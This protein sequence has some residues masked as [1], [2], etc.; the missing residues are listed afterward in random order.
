[1]SL[2]N[3]NQS[4]SIVTAFFDIGRGNWSKKTGS[5]DRL[6]RTN[7]QYFNYF[8]SLA[9]LE[10]QMIVYVAPEHKDK[11]LALRQGRPTE[12]VTI[13]FEQRFADCISKVEK[14]QQDPS[15][16]QQINPEQI[17]QPEY[18][19]AK[20]VL[21]NNL[22]PYFVVNAINDG[23][24]SNNLVAWVDFGYCR[25]DEAVAGISNWYHDFDPNY[26][27]LF[28]VRRR[29]RIAKSLD[30][31]PKAI[32]NNEVY[33]IG[34]SFVGTKD[35]WLEFYEVVKSCQKQTLANNMV[36]DD[37]SMLFMAYLSRPDF[38]KLHYLGKNQ[39]F[40]MFQKFNQSKLSSIKN[41]LRNLI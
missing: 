13:D 25:T 12:V 8:K 19:S 7:E 14:I 41:R 33:A 6:T 21:V 40:S 18:W 10:N 28:R 35:K 32:L 38:I 15:F 2:D 22:K 5:E 30:A 4:I 1:M 34:S 39:W 26:M 11:V 3:I 17:K 27:H 29:Y 37:Q 31:I 20:Y 9:R 24:V 16:R 36:D 23:L